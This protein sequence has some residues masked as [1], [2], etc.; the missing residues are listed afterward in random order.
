M[1]QAYHRRMSSC[2]LA[3]VGAGIVGLA[4]AWA[5]VKRGLRVAV[6]EREAR[7]CDASVRNFGFVTVSGQE[8]SVTRPRALRSLALW[9]E[10]AAGA[11]IPIVQRG[12]VIVARREEAFEVLDQFA[13]SPMGEGCEMWD[14]ARTRREMPMAAV[15][16]AGALWSAHEI[17]IE[18]R[19]ALARIAAWLAARGV[20]FHW[21]CAAFDVE[22]GRLRHSGGGIEAGATVFAPGNGMPALFPSI[23]AREQVHICKLQMMRLA[24]PGWKLPGV[25]MSDLSLA[26]Y[27]GFAAMPAAARLQARLERECADALARGIHVIVAQSSDGSLVVGDSHEYAQTAEAFSDARTDALILDEMGALFG[28]GAVVTERWNGYYPVARTQPLL[29]EGVGDRA[30]LALVTSG[31]GMST[32]FAIGEETIAELFG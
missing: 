19:D 16:V 9:E 24:P 13:R 1:R 10:V 5:G 2:D 27:E 4:H 15:N 14:A 23:A 31:T 3:V 7:A 18:A 28:D 32:A 26:R 12:A 8:P 21:R 29:R 25:A 20:E 11:G 17:R 6:I 22:G 30:R